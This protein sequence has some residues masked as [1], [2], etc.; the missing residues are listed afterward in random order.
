MYTYI[1]TNWSCCIHLHVH[2]D[3]SL[4]DECGSKEGPKGDEKVTTRD[5]CQIKEGVWYLWG[6]EWITAF[7][8]HT[9]T[10]VCTCI[11]MHSVYMYMYML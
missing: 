9:H 8:S 3:D 5:A 2:L 10:H 6:G 1:G 7:Y 11:Y 4:P